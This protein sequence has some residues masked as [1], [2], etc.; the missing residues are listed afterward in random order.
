MAQNPPPC[1]LLVVRC[2]QS[3]DVFSFFYGA[4]CYTA[5]IA[6]RETP[7]QT[8]QTGGKSRPPTC[9]F[10][11]QEPPE[12]TEKKKKKGKFSRSLANLSNTGTGCGMYK[13]G[14]PIPDDGRR[15]ATQGMQSV[16]VPRP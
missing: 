16:S 12:V 14:I 11:P 7:Y 5:A 13:E 3:R 9:I 15:G 1:V 6:P 2:R 4:V 8:P 10:A